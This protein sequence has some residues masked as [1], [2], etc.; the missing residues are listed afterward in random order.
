MSINQEVDKG[1]KPRPGHTIQRAGQ[2]RQ[3][4]KHGGRDQRAERI[5][6]EGDDPKVRS[7]GIKAM[8]RDL[9]GSTTLVRLPAKAMAKQTCSP[10]RQCHHRPRRGQATTCLDNK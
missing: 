5:H 10:C 1:I 9:Q 3:I 4:R 8:H 2:T 7:P 6:P